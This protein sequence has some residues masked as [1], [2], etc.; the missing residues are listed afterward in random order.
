MTQGNA[1]RQGRE[2]TIF[3][4]IRQ[5]GIQ[6]LW[7]NR[8]ISAILILICANIFNN[9]VVFLINIIIARKFGPGNFGIFSLAMSVM[10]AINLIVDLGI[11]LTVVR[12]YNLYSTDVQRQEVLLLSLLIWKVSMVIVLVI[13][14]LPLGILTT[15]IFGLHSSH[16]TLF[17][18]SAASAGIF[19]LWLYFQSYL[20]AHKRFKKLAIYIA[21]CAFLRLLC[22]LAIF[23]WLT[24][25]N[26]LPL[27][28]SSVYTGPLLI[29]I[30]VGLTPVMIYLFKRGTPR[31]SV[32]KSNMYEI[33][34]Y[35]KWVAISGLCHGLIYRG[36]QF[37]LATRTT[38]FELGIFSA[39]FVF[40]L[41][42]TP[43]NAA[44]RTV[45]FPHVTAYKS[46]NDMIRHLDRMKKIFPYY[47]IF[48]I[49]SICCLAA[50]QIFFLGNKY[51]TALPVFL[52][53]TFALTMTIFLGLASM[54]VHTLMRPEIDAY[55]NIG[56]LI[57]S[58]ILVYFLAPSMGAIGGAFSYALP[59]VLGEIL[60]VLYVRKLIYER[61]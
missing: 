54:L 50:I 25:S 61:K 15:R 11:N 21:F 34:R 28:F 13:I 52:I 53:T 55:T 20:Q 41:A 6:V 57:V 43:F 10:V 19:G 26:N 30:A 5:K 49:I 42:F 29:A 59:V 12:Y 48:I 60:M 4:Q 7:H 1:K 44:V 45:F 2:D 56:R 17:C 58:S 22:F 37:I 24:S 3:T 46:K 40:T 27:T 8:K 31:F 18:L 23:F 33:L 51:T 47:V 39:G 16:T 35:G 9:L 36:I 32:I 38:K 14:S